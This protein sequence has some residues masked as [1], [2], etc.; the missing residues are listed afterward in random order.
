MAVKPIP[1]GY[2]SITPY[3]S[4]KGAAEA[5]AFYKQAFGAIELFCMPTLSGEIG[6][7]EI[8]IGD[9][10]VMLASPC[11]EGVFRSPRSLGGSP[12]GLHF[13][14]DVDGV[15]PLERLALGPRASRSSAT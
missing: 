8:K 15:R 12:A 4:I 3:L 10:S 9:S 2:R 14:V 13:Y 7:A 6:Y 1:D 5:I 11:G